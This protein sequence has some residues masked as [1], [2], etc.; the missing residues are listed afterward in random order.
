MTHGTSAEHPAPSLDSIVRVLLEAGHPPEGI[1]DKARLW[2]SLRP[3]VDGVER[4][5]EPEPRS[6]SAKKDWSSKKGWELRFAAR[7]PAGVVHISNLLRPLGIETG[8]PYPDDD[9]ILVPVSGRRHPWLTSLLALDPPSSYTVSAAPAPARARPQGRSTSPR[10]RT[11]RVRARTP[12]LERDAQTVRQI[13]ATD[14]TFERSSWRGQ[15][16]WAGRCLQCDALLLIGL[17]GEPVSAQQIVWME[18]DGETEVPLSGKGLVCM[19]CGARAQ[20][21]EAR[22]DERLSGMLARMKERRKERWRG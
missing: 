1:E 22:G 7:S 5:P 4:P 21:L 15:P 6:E 10:R 13:I 16:V 12:I 9:R 8:R 14:A 17:D 3:L 11:S 20:S 2:L 18:G 19:R